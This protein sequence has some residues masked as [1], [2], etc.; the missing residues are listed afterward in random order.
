MNEEARFTKVRNE[1]NS[2]SASMC[3]AK[4]L[5][6]TIHLQNGVT[7][8]CHHP[9]THKIPLAEIKADSSALHNTRHKK[10]QRK[11]MLEG[12]RPEECDYCWKIEDANPD[13]FSDR[14]YKSADNWAYPHLQEVVTEK[15][16]TNIEPTY[17][18]VSFGNE[19]QFKCAYCSPVVS[20]G[21]LSEFL[22]HGHYSNQQNFDLDVLKAEN[23]Y[24]YS[25]DEPNPYVDAF[26]NWWPKLSKKLEV[27][28]ITGGEP[29]LNPNTFRFLESLIQTPMPNLDVA[30][31]SNL[32]VPDLYLNR[33]LDLAE[34]ITSQKLVKKLEI[35]T[36]VD[37]YG[38]QAE[39]VRFGLNFNKLISNI[40]TVL[41]RLP[42][43]NIVI[44]CTF[45]VFSVPGFEEFLKI[46]KDLKLK[47][48]GANSSSRIQLSIPY[49]RHP[50][51]MAANILP[52]SFIPYVE[53]S[54][55]YMLRNSYH[56]EDFYQIFSEFEMSQLR[57]I[58]DWLRQDIDDE[59]TKAHFRR[60]FYQFFKE[61]DSRK[62]TSLIETFP[63]FKEFLDTIQL[64]LD[65]E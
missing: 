61:Y 26:W 37:T 48:R 62:G 13:N 18:E 27:F 39:Y 65:N 50:M 58:L 24:P 57:R 12:E 29:L 49:L 4:W 30:I 20:S 3:L 53:R 31:N 16:N 33:F 1:L 8:S 41:D 60:E 25:K 15:W 34:K 59:V 64:E 38:A 22:K 55:D 51:F 2:K 54:L 9:P 42:A 11:K 21:I 45:N 14:T 6:V 19:C 10:E 32:S 43:T 52:E 40:R 23:I 56:T 36:S 63:E 28:R 46:L 47:Y 5:Q 44:M 17:V 35:Y 7:H